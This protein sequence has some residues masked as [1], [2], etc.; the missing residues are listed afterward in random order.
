MKIDQMRNEIKEVYPNKTWSNKVDRMLDDQVLA[1]YYS[2]L[3]DG[4]L[5]PR[6]LKVRNITQEYS[7]KHNLQLT[8]DDLLIGMDTS[9]GE[10]WST[11]TEF[12]P[13]QHSKEVTNE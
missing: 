8:F 10:D 4:R 9:S 6:E 11:T 3:K 1:V 2:F 7:E 5:G 12:N 13:N